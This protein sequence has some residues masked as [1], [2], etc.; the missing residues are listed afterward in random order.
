MAP[1]FIPLNDRRKKGSHSAALVSPHHDLA[2]AD[3]L[4]HFSFQV[5]GLGPEDS[6]NA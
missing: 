2:V 6:L 5:I 4:I 3:V 1:F